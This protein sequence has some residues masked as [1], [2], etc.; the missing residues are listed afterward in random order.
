[1]CDHKRN[2]TS[3]MLGIQLLWAMW[4]WNNRYTRDCSSCTKTQGR[5]G[6]CS[7]SFPY[8]RDLEERNS[9]VLG[10]EFTRAARRWNAADTIDTDQSHRLKT[11]GDFNRCWTVAHM[12][13]L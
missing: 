2:W 9:K 10:N 5:C 1:M 4:G 3:S 11:K 12:R 6:R 7:W 8:L 13:C